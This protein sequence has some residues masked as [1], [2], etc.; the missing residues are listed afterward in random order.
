MC[1]VKIKNL[2]FYKLSLIMVQ[3]NSFPESLFII[4]G[5]SKRWKV[6][7]EYLEKPIRGTAVLYS[8]PRVLL[9]KGQR[10]QWEKF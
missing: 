8:Q 6:V 9:C 7:I 2:L 3:Q 5:L 10:K 1:I 4:L